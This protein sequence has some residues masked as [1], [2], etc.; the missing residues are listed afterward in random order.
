MHACGVDDDVSSL[1]LYDLRAYGA[2]E[3]G[4]R[5]PILFS[6]GVTLTERPWVTSDE[7]RSTGTLSRS[8]RRRITTCL[9]GSRTG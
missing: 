2:D 7:R 3:D 8:G 9:S 6:V 4:T 5:V 1:P